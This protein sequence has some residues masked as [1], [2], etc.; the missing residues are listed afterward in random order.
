MFERG[1]RAAQLRVAGTGEAERPALSKQILAEA[2]E[3]AEASGG[4][5]G[6]GAVSSPERR[7]L[8]A[9]AAA[10]GVEM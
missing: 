7:A 9:L 2:T 8:E 3:V 5:L 4:L 6:R 10:L 1:R